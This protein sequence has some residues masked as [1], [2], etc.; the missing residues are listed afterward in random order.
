MGIM[1][2]YQKKGIGKE[3][4]R[5][6]EE[7]IKN[8]GYKTIRLNVGTKN[9][10]AFAFWIRNGYRNIISVIKYENGF[11]DINLEKAMT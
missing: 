2:K 6:L 11:M 7:E 4:Y 10:E 5:L 3:V 9:I 8:N 1:K